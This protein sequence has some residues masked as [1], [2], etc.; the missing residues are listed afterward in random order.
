[1]FILTSFTAPLAATT[2]FS[3]IGDSVRHGPHH[4]AQKSTRTG[5]FREDS[6]TSLAKAWVVVSM[7]R[8]P[9]CAG[10]VFAAGARP[11]IGVLIR[12]TY[13][14]RAALRPPFCVQMELSGA[15]Y[16]SGAGAS[17]SS[18]TMRGSWPVARMKAR[19]PAEAIDVVAVLT[20]GWQLTISS[21]ISAASSTT[22]TRGGTSL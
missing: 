9:F 19:S 4:G 20:R 22:W 3:M 13:Q 12:R 7:T 21:C 15:F 8:A 1:M 6:I 16:N 10:A 17:S 18:G 2:A 5:C 11:D 14:I